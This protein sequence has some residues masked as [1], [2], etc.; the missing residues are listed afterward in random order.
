[1]AERVLCVGRDFCCPSQA[2]MQEWP[3]AC[4]TTADDTENLLFPTVLVDFISALCRRALLSP[5]FPLMVR[6]VIGNVYTSIEL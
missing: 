5:T 6:N 1:M 4:S 3:G 2:A